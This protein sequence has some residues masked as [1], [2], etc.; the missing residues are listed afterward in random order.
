MSHLHFYGSRMYFAKKVADGAYYFIYFANT[1][2]ETKN[3]M[4]NIFHDY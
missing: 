4:Q 3:V 1:K 2:H